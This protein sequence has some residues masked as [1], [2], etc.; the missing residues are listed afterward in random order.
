MKFKNYVN[1]YTKNNRIFSKED[2]AE[3]TVREAFK[4][5]KGIISQNRRI[6]VPSNAELQNSSNVIWVNSYTREDGTPV[7]GYWRSKGG[8][9]G[10]VGDTDS[11]IMDEQM[12]EPSERDN[13]NAQSAG[14]SENGDEDLSPVSLIVDLAVA[15]S[16]LFFKDSKVGEY[17]EA[18][19]PIIKTIGGKLF[20]EEDDELNLETDTAENTETPETPDLSVTKDE[21]GTPTGGAS[22]VNNIIDSGIE[23]YLDLPTGTIDSLRRYRDNGISDDNNMNLW[24]EIQGAIY[25][26]LLHKYFPM[27]SDATK[28]GMHKLEIAKKDKNVSIIRDL[29]TLNNQKQKAILKSMGAK[30]ENSGIIYHEASDISQKFKNSPELEAHIAKIRDSVLNGNELKDEKIVFESSKSDF[31][32][33]KEKIDRHAFIHNAMITN[34]KVDEHGVY[35]CDLLDFSDFDDKP[36]ETLLD[37]PNKWG[38][39]MQERKL[40]KNFYII[41]KIRKKVN[42]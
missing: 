4:N 6:G 23:K 15:I 20:G 31:I 16:Q 1:S 14:D 11:V 25:E 34:Q 18:F 26:N 3:M 22:E 17:I 10:I 32:G 27:S 37:I 8:S 39:D 5:K 38:Y 35:T 41:I 29:N 36:I 21:E 42:W 40:Y 28:N 19:A 30:E 13:S 2:I 33:N 12:P 7:K 24:E 9:G